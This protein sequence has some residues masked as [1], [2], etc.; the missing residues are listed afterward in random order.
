[1]NLYLEKLKAEEY[2][3]LVDFIVNDD[4][5][6]HVEEKPSE[7]SLKEKVEK[8]YYLSG[9]TVTLWIVIEQRRVGFIRLF[10]L[11]DSTSMFDV[12]IANSERQKGLGV[13]SLEKMIDYVFN[14]YPHIVRIEGYTRID[15]VPMQKCFDKTLFVKEAHHRKSWLDKDGTLVDSIGYAV[16]RNDWTSNSKT[17]VVWS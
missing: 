13:L 11:E 1:M 10:D 3:E 5:E 12:R 16:T 9:G 8:G 2:A 17:P 14:T 4:W 7:T 6:Y 15:N